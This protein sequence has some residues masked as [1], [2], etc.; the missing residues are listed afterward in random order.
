MNRAGGSAPSANG[1]DVSTAPKVTV[2]WSSVSGNMVV[3]LQ[4]N[5]QSYMP[6]L[7]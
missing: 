6:L 3:Y 5:G 4:M 2:Y 1:G 7:R